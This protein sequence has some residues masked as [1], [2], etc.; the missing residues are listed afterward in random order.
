VSAVR[1]QRRAIGIRLLNLSAWMRRQ[2]WLKVLYRHFPATLRNRTS[3]ALAAR[4][5][6]QLKFRRTAGWNHAR[7]PAEPVAETAGSVRAAASGVNIFAYVRGQF[8]LAEGARQYAR[9]LLAEGYPVAI[10]DIDIDVP[11]GMDDR[12]LDPYIGGEAPYEVNLVFVNPDYLEQAMASIGR[13]RLGNR[14]TIACWFWEL[15]KFPDAWRPALNRVD[16][17][18]VSTAF[19]GRAVATVTD[20]PVWI[21]PL[22]VGEPVDSGLTRADFGL[23]D[24]DFIFLCSFDFNSFVARKNPCAAIEA[25]RRAFADRRPNVKLLV[26]SSNGHRHPEALRSLLNTAGADERIILRDELL[27]RE[28]LAALQRCVDAYVSLHRAEGFGLG[29]AECMRLGKPVI[30]TAWSGNMEFM[31]A[32]NSCLVD[33]QL[34]PV[35]EGEYPYHVGQC[36]AEADVDHAAGLMRRLV[37]DRTFAAG[38]G[39]RAA[40]DIRSRLSPHV[41][42]QKIIRRIE[43]QPSR[44]GIPPASATHSGAVD[45]QERAP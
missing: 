25:F 37:D 43:S 38:I 13:E 20:K 4:A 45:R 30:A 5:N 39:S 31:T 29:L 1:K 12:S 2:P 3:E 41:A 23:E 28:D 19:V 8:G 9:A 32:D 10:I 11:H 40:R 6:Q 33:Y 42:A 36:W 16:E 26:K 35:G 18:M 17:V 24:D 22:P 21:V 14:H 7:R 34:V 27:D 44:S 15:E